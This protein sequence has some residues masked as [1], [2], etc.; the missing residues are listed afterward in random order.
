MAAPTAATA[1]KRA[2]CDSSPQHEERRGGEEHRGHDREGEPRTVGEAVP[3]VGGVAAGDGSTPI[4]RR[5]TTTRRHEGAEPEVADQVG[6][7]EASG[8]GG[9]E[10]GA[11]ERGAATVKSPNRTDVGVG[12]RVRGGV[13]TGATRPE[14]TPPTAAPRKNGVSREATANMAP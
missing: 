14:A 2:Q 3:D 12:P 7:V 1:L 5:A 13:G 8:V 11:E 10:D 4:S 9:Q 6:C